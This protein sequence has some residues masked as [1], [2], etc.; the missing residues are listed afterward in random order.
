MTNPLIDK[1]ID[2]VY[3]GVPLN[4]VCPYCEKEIEADV[5]IDPRF[6]PKDWERMAERLIMDIA[7]GLAPI[8][9]NLTKEDIKNL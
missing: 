4:L 5:I 2:I 9:Q 8:L 7:K 6:Y 3:G 1:V